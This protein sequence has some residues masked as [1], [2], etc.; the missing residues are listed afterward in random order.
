M[1]PGEIIQR[2]IHVGWRDG[3]ATA[4]AYDR[5]GR[6]YVVTARHVV[7]G[8]DGSE[9]LMVMHDKNWRPLTCRVVGHHPEDD[10]SVL[11]TDGY[12]AHYPNAPRN[13]NQG[14][15]LGQ[16]AYFLGFPHGWYGDVGFVNGGYPVPFAKRAI[17]SGFG[18]GTEPFF[19]DGHNNPGFS[20]GPVIAV[21]RVN[22]ELSIVGVVSGYRWA[23]KRV[24]HA[25]RETELLI[26]E[27]TGLISAVYIARA[28]DLIDANP[29]GREI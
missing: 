11:A 28:N 26:E 13:T 12:W 24:K 17:V 23:P 5:D 29:I 20:G 7:E 18:P 22:N 27:N 25:G 14:I 16:D 15:H 21:D 19:L 6:Q 2:V 1:I 9:P 8:F 4:F 3:T 10:L